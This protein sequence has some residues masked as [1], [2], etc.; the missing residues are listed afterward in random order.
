MIAQAEGAYLGSFVFRLFS[1]SHPAPQSTCLL[2]RPKALGR[3]EVSIK[4]KH[5]NL[6]RH[7]H[8]TI[9]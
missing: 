6:E 4:S 1:L 9:E 3:G 2:R 8:V 7:Y 5:Q